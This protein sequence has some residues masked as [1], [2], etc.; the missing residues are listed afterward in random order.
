MVIKQSQRGVT[1]IEL[2]VVIGIFA[3]VSS[4]LMFNY[5]DFNSNISIRNL[6]QE[7]ALSIRKAQTY[8]TS[9][10]SIDVARVS[11]TSYPAYGIS[12]K[13]NRASDIGEIAR[14]ETLQ[15]VTIDEER[16][17]GMV[18]S[19]RG[20]IL[21]ADI[22]DPDSGSATGDR[23][24]NYTDECGNPQP[25][26]ECVENFGISTADRIVA[27]CTDLDAW[28]CGA[29]QVNIMFHRPSPDADICVVENGSCMDRKATYAKVV[30]Q[31]P[32][33]IQK[34]VT[35]WNTGQIGVQ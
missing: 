21:F 22:P 20:F 18:P 4:V 35:V 17:S 31:S 34:I 2:I 7:V 33:G 1:L 19:D 16:A 9:V 6:A 24:Y 25:G 27:I 32:K 10:Q 30:L 12:F 15:E 29:E 11:T 13:V 26:S 8:A 23:L 14:S 3:V 5:S 28:R